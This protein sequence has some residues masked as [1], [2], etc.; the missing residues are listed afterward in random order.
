[1]MI[2]VCVMLIATYSSLAIR[3]YCATDDS[4]IPTSRIN[5]GICDC[6]DGSDEWAVE[7]MCNMNCDETRRKRDE[8]ARIL[9]VCVCVCMCVCAK[10]IL[11]CTTALLTTKP[12]CAGGYFNAC[13]VCEA[14]KC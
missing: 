13:T 7:G 9:Q 14:G 3:F 4:Y 6:C 2:F 5:D 10:E 11:R 8:S 12:C 1:M